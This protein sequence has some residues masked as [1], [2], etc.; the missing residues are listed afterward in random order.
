MNNS[1]VAGIDVSKEYSDYCILTPDNTVFSRGKIFHHPA[2]MD[3]L[4]RQLD[5]VEKAFGFKPI[6]IMEST[7]Y[8]HRIL[9]RYLTKHGHKV[10]LIN[11]LQSKAAADFNIRSAKTDKIDA[12][13]LALLYG[14][15]H[16]KPSVV[17]NSTIQELRDLCRNHYSLEEQLVVSQERLRAYV[18]QTLPGFEKAFSRL[19]SKSGLMLLSQY[20][21]KEELNAAGIEKISEIISTASGM[22][23]SWSETKA[24]MILSSVNNGQEFISSQSHSAI[25]KSIAITILGIFDAIIEN[26]NALELLFEQNLS[27]AEDRSLLMTIP[28]V[29]KQT[30]A[31]LISETGN[32]DSFK[33]Y[34]QLTAYYGLD[35]KVNKSG[36]CSRKHLGVSKKGSP[37]VRKMLRMAVQNSV[38]A[39]KKGKAANP[40]LAQFYKTKA[41]DK[42]PKTA[43]TAVMRK[44]TAI[45]FAVLRD[46]KPFE[47]RTPEEHIAIMGI[48]RLQ[49][50]AI[51]A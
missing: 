4:C 37:L 31:V 49:N 1:P 10:M 45:I 44:L 46:R 19:V 35:P 32:F 3:K 51:S 23:Q 9:Y 41:K 43:E 29:G 20:A 42:S 33:N 26:D 30:A 16:L 28:G 5:D 15:K 6:C 22:G 17:P 11:A 38:Y 2:S 18:E 27:L 34:R 13:K 40:V 48:E 25:I 39:T 14:M 7:A 8:Y 12:Y 36:K 47:L 21:S 24:Q 50:K